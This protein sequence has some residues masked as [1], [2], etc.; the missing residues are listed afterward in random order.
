MSRV[1][2]APLERVLLRPEDEAYARLAERTLAAESMRNV[3]ASS[4]GFGFI[5]RLAIAFVLV[6]GALVAALDF[7]PRV[8][9]PAKVAPAPAPAYP[10]QLLP[11]PGKQ[12]KR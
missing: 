1:V 11:P 10:V 4:Y 7:F 9:R 8:L 6:M 3:T 12:E 5:I 2:P